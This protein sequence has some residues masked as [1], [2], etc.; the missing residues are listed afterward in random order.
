MLTHNSFFFFIFFFIYFSTIYIYIV[1]KPGHC[2]QCL[3]A[4]QRLSHHW[5]DEAHLSWSH[6]VARWSSINHRCTSC[7]LF[8]LG[9][10]RRAV[11]CVV[12]YVTALQAQSQATAAAEDQF[13]PTTSGTF[14]FVTVWCLWTQTYCW[15]SLFPA[16]INSS[17]ETTSHEL[18]VCESDSRCSTW[19][20]TS[21]SALLILTSTKQTGSVR[22]VAMCWYFRVFSN[23]LFH[24]SYLDEGM[25]SAPA[26]IKEGVWCD[27][28]S[29]PPGFDCFFQNH[30]RHRS[31]L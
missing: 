29:Q 8:P 1:E 4:P 19:I 30:K 9:T 14:Q 12:Q 21:G 23:L 7:K 25:G 17:Y 15:D 20:S 24:Q 16:A 28:K 6:S 26:L 18:A 11:Q 27:M 13:I 22:R 2:S 10:Y 3:T 31:D 5:V